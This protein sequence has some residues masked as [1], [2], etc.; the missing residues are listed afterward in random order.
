MAKPI[1]YNPSEVLVAD[2][3]TVLAPK[4]GTFAPPPRGAVGKFKADDSTTYPD[5]WAPIGLT[6]AETLPTFSSDGGD[7]TVIDTAEVAAVRNIRGNITTKFEFTLHTFNKRV[8]QLTQGGNDPATLEET[9]AEL[10]QWSGGKPRTVNT[11]LLFIRADSEMT[12][13]DYMP[14]AQLSANGRGE[15]SKGALVPIPVT[16]TVLAP[17]AEQVTAGAKDAIATIVPKKKAVAPVAGG[18]Q[19]AAGGPGARAGG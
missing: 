5:G 17:T 8:L 2:F 7:A 13:F 6:S 11:S 12:V 3:V 4:T 19:P 1:E 15:T 14:N 16:A 10:I 9:E 18:G